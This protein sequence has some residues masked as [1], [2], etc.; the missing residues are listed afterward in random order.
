MTWVKSL[1]APLS[2]EYLQFVIGCS[3]TKKRHRLIAE[4]DTDGDWV[5]LIASSGDR[6]IIQ[7]RP[8]DYQHDLPLPLLSVHWS[9]MPSSERPRIADLAAVL[10]HTS[11]L[12]PG[13][14]VMKEHCWWYAEM[15]F[16][17]MCA[18]H[19]N[20]LPRAAPGRP[21][22]AQP[23]LMH[24]PSA[25]YRYSY[26]VLDERWLKRNILVEQAKWFRNEMDKGGI[27]RW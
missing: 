19:L 12:S 17:Q 5:Y 20:G 13:Y 14:N 9:Y 22:H 15:V 16:E 27:L 24:W 18:S 26:I 4:R 25:S 1:S 8:Y 21:E 7:H 6:E 10:A 23:D 11:Q 2:H 3:S